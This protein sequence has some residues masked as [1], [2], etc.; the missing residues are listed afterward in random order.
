VSS[1]ALVLASGSPQRRAILTQIGVTFTVHVTDAD[2]LTAGPP[3]EVVSENAF[4]KARAAA[5]VIGSQLPVLG[6]DTIVALGAQ[7][8]GK[9]PDRDAARE[10]LQALAGREHVVLSGVCVIRDGDVRTATARTRVR[11]RALDDRELETYLETGEWRERAGGYAIQE[12]GALLVAEI[13]GD[14]LNVVGLPVATLV[15]MMPDLL[16]GAGRHA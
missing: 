8:F 7:I 16:S 12:R 11:M 9:P 14:Y 3:P 15:E 2:E 13:A 10:M 6:V 1:P 4:R 5:D